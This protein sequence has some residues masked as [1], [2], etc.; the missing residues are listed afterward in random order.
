MFHFPIAILIPDPQYPYPLDETEL[1]NRYP[2]W[3]SFDQFRHDFRDYC[4]Q[5]LK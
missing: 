4:L 5:T 1:Q 2:I 3:T